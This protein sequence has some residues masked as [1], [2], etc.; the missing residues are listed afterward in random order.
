MQLEHFK[1]SHV[2]YMC[3]YEIKKIKHIRKCGTLNAYYIYIKYIV[4]ALKE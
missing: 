2:Y 4:I 3:A 1:S